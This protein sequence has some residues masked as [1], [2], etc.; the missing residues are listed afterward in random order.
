MRKYNYIVVICGFAENVMTERILNILNK[1]ILIIKRV[2]V[3]IYEFYFLYLS[4]LHL[5]WKGEIK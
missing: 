3:F 2:K 4:K 1:N 5:F